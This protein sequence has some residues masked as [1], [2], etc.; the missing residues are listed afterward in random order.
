ME[1]PMAGS[2][3]QQNSGRE[4]LELQTGVK[5]RGTMPRLVG[6]RKTVNTQPRRQD[7]PQFF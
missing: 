5:Q 4:S 2:G 7:L 6:G 3:E 1:V